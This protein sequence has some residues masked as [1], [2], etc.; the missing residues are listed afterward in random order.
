MAEGRQHTRQAVVVG[1]GIVGLTSALALLDSGWHVDVVARRVGPDTT[2][3]G[4]GAICLPYKATHPDVLR[5]ANTTL[6]HFQA[7][8]G[9]AAG[10]RAGVRMGKVAAF[11]RQTDSFDIER[12]YPFRH[13]FPS[14]RVLP[15]SC[16]PTFGPGVSYSHAVEYETA[17][18]DPTLYLPYLLETYSARG[19]K[20]TLC[21]LTSLSEVTAMYPTASVVI[22]CAGLGGGPLSRD[23]TMYPIRGALVHTRLLQMPHGW[24]AMI[25]ADGD[26]TGLS[27]YIISRC[28]HM[29]VGGTEYTGDARTASDSMLYER[30]I[31]RAQQW[32]LP[33]VSEKDVQGSW[34]GLRPGRV[35]VR[36]EVE[37]QGIDTASLDRKA[38][39]GPII[40]NYGHG[41]SGYT[42]SWGCALDVVSLAESCANEPSPTS[43]F[44]HAKL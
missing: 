14:F 6:C 7:F 43:P 8:A 17:F 26:G 1:A 27:S 44:E 10:L 23:T 4:A 24:S 30:I 37:Q 39:G 38:C 11:Y 41:G 32:L 20:I 34:T 9:T 19:C 35:E 31:Q 22:N 36:L 12:L 2:S 29:V 28:S 16:W 33:S 18:V 25:D 3:Y 5:W 15:K 21:D 42:L 40:H 13:M